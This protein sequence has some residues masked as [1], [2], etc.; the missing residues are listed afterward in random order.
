[1]TLSD[2]LDMGLSYLASFLLILV[3]LI[4]TLRKRTYTNIC[5][6]LVFFLLAVIETAD[7]FAM[8]VMFDTLF[9]KKAVLFLEALLPPAFL[10]LSLS[11]SGKNPIRALAPSWW[12][13]VLISFLFPVVVIAMPLDNFFYMPD[14]RSDKMLFLGHVGYWF[15]LGIMAYCILAMVN[16][17]AVFSSSRGPDRWR[18]KFEYLGLCSI[19]SVMIYY[20]SQGLLYRTINMGL[21]PVRS[22]ILIVG[23]FLTG[24]SKLIRGDDTRI[25]VSRYV[26]YRSLTL[27]LVGMYLLLLGLFGEG[28]KYFGSGFAKNALIVTAFVIGILI[29]VFVFSEGLRRKA[30]VVLNKHFFANKYDYREEW[31]KF[32]DRLSLCRTLA[33]VKQTVLTTFI[34]TFGLKGAS[35]YTL[36]YEHNIYCLGANQETKSEQKKTVQLSPA[37]VSYFIERNRV[38]NP[39]DGEYLPTP[40]ESDFIKQTGARFIVPMI[41]NENIEGLVILTEQISPEEF[42]FEDYDIMKTLARQAALS[43]ANFR[44]SEA[45][46]ESREM[47][48]VAK[49]SSFLIHDLKNLTYSMGLLLENSDEYIN[50]PDFQ[51]DMI[52]TIRNTVSKMNG[53]IQKLRQVP[54]KTALSKM[55][56][57]LQ[58]VV[59]DTVNDVR[60]MKHGIEIGFNGSSAMSLVD[61]DEIK[62]IVLNLLLNAC[63][64]VSDNG[65][66][67]AETG[68][69]NGGCY[70]R[71][72]DNGCGMARDFIANSLFKAFRTTKQK[73][74]GVG[75]YQCMQIAEAHEGRIE[76]KSEQGKGSAFTVHLPLYAER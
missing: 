9:M 55:P 74:L 64:A 50:E 35:L 11:Y 58:L 67:K 47:A 17:E 14:F 32:T 20:F 39:L 76:V 45:L 53:L 7:Q 25:K 59:R 61:T 71:V 63:D 16:L 43:I 8:N 54:E 28:M 41:S 33:D 40:V 70:I 73:G 30:M 51:K 10:M 31:L 5:L 15:Y 36:D 38:L 26:L 34:D 2:T 72:T 68:V 69:N 46:G 22:G 4:I 18:I 52:D 21:I 42:I 75:L 23:V 3:A 6:C 66:I 57:D 44:L 56:A 19:L 27:L 1:M 49:V 65:I 37:L 60:N 29:L 62:K 48:A 12:A 13:P 24:Y